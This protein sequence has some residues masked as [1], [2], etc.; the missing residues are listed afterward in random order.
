MK[1]LDYNNKM[2]EIE[3]EG[4]FA[5]VVQHEVDYLD[6]KIY[7]DYLS[8]MKRDLLMRKM[9]K[10]IKMHPPHIHGTGCKH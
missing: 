1:Y 3:A 7:L 4:F 5:T 6:G 10:F 9:Q 2:N 8:K